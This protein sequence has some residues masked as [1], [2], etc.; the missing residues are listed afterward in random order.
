MSSYIAVVNS[1]WFHHYRTSWSEFVFICDINGKPTSDRKSSISSYSPTV[2]THTNTKAVCKDTSWHCSLTPELGNTLNA[3][4]LAAAS[5]DVS[6]LRGVSLK[7][8]ACSDTPTLQH[9]AKQQKTCWTSATVWTRKDSSLASEIEFYLP[10]GQG[11]RNNSD[12]VEHGEH[13]SVWRNC[14]DFHCSWVPQFYAFP[15]VYKI[16]THR[17]SFEYVCKV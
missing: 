16:V 5:P 4:L 2:E 8:T 1:R 3:C 14:S 12:K 11:W 17:A 13:V 15:R 7:T 6:A 10:Q 9:G